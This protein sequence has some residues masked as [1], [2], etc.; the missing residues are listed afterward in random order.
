LRSASGWLIRASN[1]DEKLEDVLEAIRSRPWLTALIRDIKAGK[2]TSIVSISLG[3]LVVTSALGAG[4]E[5]GIRH[6]KDLAE[7]ASGLEKWSRRRKRHR[8]R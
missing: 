1:I 8:R 3:A 7:L 5:L 6:G 4:V 2:R